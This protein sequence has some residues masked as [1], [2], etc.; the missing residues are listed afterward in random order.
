VVRG[1]A[2][3]PQCWYAGVRQGC[4]LSPLLYLFVAEAS[5]RWLRADT[6]LGI[7]LASHRL[8]SA[9]HAD[10]TKVYVPDLQEDT[11]KHLLERTFLFGQSCEPCK[12]L[13]CPVVWPFRVC[14]TC[15]WCHSGGI[16]Y[17]S[18]C[19]GV[20][21]HPVTTTRL[22]SSVDTRPGLR[23]R[24][25]C[26]PFTPP[27]PMTP[28]WQKRLAALTSVHQ[29]CA[30]LHLSAMGRGLCMTTYGTSA[31]FY[32]AEFDGLPSS[33]VPSLE[34][35][36]AGVVDGRR[37]VQ[38][39]VLQAELLHGPAREGGFGLLPLV[40]HTFASHAKWLCRTLHTLVTMLV[41]EA[42]HNPAAIPLPDDLDLPGGVS[43]LRYPDWLSLAFHAF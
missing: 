25:R 3:I 10:D 16:C 23:V 41:T 6:A 31:T 35:T 39:P 36:L 5:A 42:S 30:S 34:R 7:S 27:P 18:R 32:R 21:V 43:P 28:A 37:P 1:R 22:H 11:V 24:R 20:L 8:A 38:P 4:P 26:S 13:S 15:S 19:L 33:A 12:V 17:I 9:H 14:Y 2:A 29:R 40:P